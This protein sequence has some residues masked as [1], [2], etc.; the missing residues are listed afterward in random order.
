MPDLF[1]T[2]TIRWDYPIQTDFGPFHYRFAV[3]N[4]IEATMGRTR[5]AKRKMPITAR[6]VGDKLPTSASAASTRGVIR[7]F[8]VL[9]KRREQLL[10]EAAKG[11]NKRREVRAPGIDYLPPQEELNRIESD[12]E[13]M[14]GLERYQAMSSIG[15]SAVK[16][17]GSEKVLIPWIKEIYPKREIGTLGRLR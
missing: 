15:Q 4:D 12:I 8:H 3:T 17:G 13:A 1:W 9:L 10:R 5:H 7:R 14:G 11:R 2:L 16:G 6:V